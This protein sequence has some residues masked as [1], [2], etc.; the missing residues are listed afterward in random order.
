MSTIKGYKDGSYVIRSTSTF[1]NI[2]TG[3]I[4]I[5]FRIV[6]N[7]RSNAHISIRCTGISASK[8][9]TSRIRINFNYFLRVAQ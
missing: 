5:T 7:C 9:N 4:R 1:Y 3:K 6:Q 8:A 2:L